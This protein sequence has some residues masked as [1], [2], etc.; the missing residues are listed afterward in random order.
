MERAERMIL[1]GLAL[2][3][4]ALL[5]PVLWVMLGLISFTAVAR[6]VKVWNAA[7]GKDEVI[8]RRLE[9]WREG[10]TDSRW[11]TWREGREGAGVP[12]REMAQ[13]ANAPVARWRARRQEALR[14]RPGRPDR[15]RRSGAGVHRTDS[16]PP[17]PGPTA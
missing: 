16:G 1:L 2:I 13:S 6:F 10:R 12:R 5:V 7:S 3:D 9:A 17:A 8:R 11:R 14:S 4:S 15:A